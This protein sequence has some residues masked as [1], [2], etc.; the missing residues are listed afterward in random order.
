MYWHIACQNGQGHNYQGWQ[1]FNALA[2]PSFLESDGR[3]DNVKCLLWCSVNMKVLR[4]LD[5]I[6]RVNIYR[7]K[8]KGSAELLFCKPVELNVM[9]SIHHRIFLWQKHKIMASTLVRKLKIGPIKSICTHTVPWFS[10]VYDLFYFTL[11]CLRVCPVLTY[12]GACQEF[13]L[14]DLV[15]CMMGYLK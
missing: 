11:N 14:F 12:W 1:I 6:F 7:D 15:N 13:G 2:D 9:S 4:K 5:F 10:D 3:N 8:E